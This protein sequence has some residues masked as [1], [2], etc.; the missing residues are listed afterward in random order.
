VSKFIYWIVALPLAALI[1]VFS[2]NNRAAVVIDLWPL[3]IL[4]FPLPLFS[5]ALVSMVAGFFIGSLIAWK[6]LLPSYRRAL[7]GA[8]RADKAE[9]NL[10]A[11]QERFK[12]LEKVIAD[13]SAE[14]AKLP[15]NA[16]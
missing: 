7:A 16:V 10:L 6:S 4:A 1:I 12:N 13:Q 5:I 11:T 2:F 3:D 8:K 9:C 14:I 15:P